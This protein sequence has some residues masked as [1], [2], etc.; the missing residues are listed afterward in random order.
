MLELLQNSWIVNIGTG[1]ISGFLVAILTRYAFSNKDDKELARSIESANREVLFAIRSEVS[2]S[3][4]PT[5]DVVQALISATARKYKLEARLLLKPQQLSEELIKE[6][7]DSSFI[8]SKQKTEYCQALTS[9]RPQEETELD[10]KIQKENEKFVANVEYR[11][12]LIMVFSITLGM[13]AALSTTFI[14]LRSSSPTN[15]FGKLFD[16]VFPMML[17][18]GVVVIFMNIFLMA[19]KARHKR[20]REE[21]G[22]PIPQEDEK[23]A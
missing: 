8:S 19:M 9:L 17:I 23:S 10:R 21:F 6:V 16:S 22:L 14:L 3:N 12:R 2:E 7:M 5:L 20:L 11:E 18:F 1:V 4:V 15:L 13:I